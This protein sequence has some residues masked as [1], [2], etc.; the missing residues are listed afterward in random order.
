MALCWLERTLI[1]ACMFTN[2]EGNG[3]CGLHQLHT[4]GFHLTLKV[5]G[6]DPVVL[7]SEFLKPREG[8]CKSSNA[9]T[10]SSNATEIMITATTPESM[11]SPAPLSPAAW[12]SSLYVQTGA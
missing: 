7:W 6:S 11:P 2:G 5:F 1:F 10:K 3:L 9:T 12:Q 4:T 8:R